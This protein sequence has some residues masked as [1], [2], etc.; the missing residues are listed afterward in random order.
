MKNSSYKGKHL[1]FNEIWHLIQVLKF[2]YEDVMKLKPR[3]IAEI[4][5]L[6]FG[7]IV[8]EKD[9]SLNILLASYRDND[10]N[11]KCYE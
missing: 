1:E 9:V 3:E 8:N 2:Y 7:C 10:G 4:L 5:K 6:E 11:L